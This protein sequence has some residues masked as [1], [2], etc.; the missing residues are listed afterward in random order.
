[1]KRCCW[2]LMVAGFVLRAGSVFA[3]LP[4]RS[5]AEE[6]LFS[7]ANAERTQRGLPALT[8]NERLYNA[9]RAHCEQMAE[10]ASISHQY[11]GEAGLAQRAGMAGA[12]F[13]V[14][15]ENV[16]E[17][18]TAVRIHDA[19]M[20]SPGHRANLLDV[21]VDSVGISVLSRNGQ[22]YAVEDFGKSVA[23]FSYQEQESK[24][25][26]L[27]TTVAPVTILPTTD[28]VLRTCAM[29]TGYAGKRMPWFVM[30]YTTADLS[31]LPGALAA[32]LR[33]GKL[34][35]AAVG[36]CASHNSKSFTAFNIVVM[37]FP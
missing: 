24:V 16:A 23:P 15:S 3:Q 29:S 33:K 34:H 20:H 32:Q 14:I 31:Q 30:R 19:W 4:R 10:R 26:S 11:A 5:V 22:L 6:Y 12:R 36:A 2:V 7:A 18:P 17:A 37:L 25:A 28:D 8:W 9:A 21:R 35:E 13:S 27:L 1:M